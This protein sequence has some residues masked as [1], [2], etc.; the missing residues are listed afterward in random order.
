M[1]FNWLTA[2]EVIGCVAVAVVAV[3]AFVLLLSA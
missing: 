2:I 1:N 3:I